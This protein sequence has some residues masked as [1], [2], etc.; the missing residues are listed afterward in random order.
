MEKMNS[1]EMR[2]CIDE[3]IKCGRLAGKAIFTFGHSNAAEELIDY[4]FVN[5]IEVLAILDN[6]EAKQGSS[7]RGVSVKKPS[8]IHTCTAADSIVLIAAK[9]YEAMAD[10]LRR[11]GYGGEIV[12]VV[13]YNSF[14]E[15]SLSD[16]VFAGKKARVLRGTDTLKKIRSRYSSQFLIIC[17]HNALGDVYWALSYLPAFCE[18]HCIGETA[19]VVTGDGCRQVAGLFQKESIIVLQKTEMDELVQA[20]LFVQEENCLIAHHDRPYTDIIIRY[21]DRCFLSFTN[22]Y[23]Y[24]VY[25]LDQDAKPALPTGNEAFENSGQ[26]EKGRTV[27]LSPYAKSIVQIPDAFWES[28]AEEYQAMGYLVC[29]NTAGEEKPVRGT[30]TLHVPISQ[31]VSAAEYAGC[32]I[33]IRSGLCD[34]LNP[35]R[36]RKVAVFPDCIYSTA[37]VKVDEFFHM[38]GWENVVWKA[39]DVYRKKLPVNLG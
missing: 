30:N 13:E 6:N 15:Y 33:G 5:G 35:A 29:T 34:I 18:K 16:S 22:F 10:Q 25:G 17:P 12:K 3:L 36:C 4:L 9:A 31:M 20:I 8:H 37:N 21:L 14:S 24:A 38:Y 7:Y 19:I 11:S 39:S 2:N 28:L 26:I 1:A 23:K 27:I 32:F